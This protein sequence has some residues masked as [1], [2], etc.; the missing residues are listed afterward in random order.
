MRLT[1]K[2]LAGH[3][4]V[5]LR[6]QEQSDRTG[7]HLKFGVAQARTHSDRGAAQACM[8]CCMLTA[9]FKIRKLQ[10][11]CFLHRMQS[12]TST[13]LRL[14]PRISAALYRPVFHWYSCNNLQLDS[15]DC[16]SVGSL[17]FGG[18]TGFLRHSRNI[19]KLLRCYSA[20]H[21]IFRC[22]TS[23]HA[24]ETNMLIGLQAF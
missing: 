16:K 18:V 20:Q 13:M 23:E 14:S 22:A 2:A 3:A 17:W 21:S 12:Y 4:A 15:R 9:K 6:T 11:L 24:S 1:I 19:A 5:T 10:G 8:L 7:R